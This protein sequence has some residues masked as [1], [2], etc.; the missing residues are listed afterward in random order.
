MAG[1]RPCVAV[2]GGG[3]GGLATAIGLRRRG[4][5]AVVYEQSRA[6]APQGAGIAVGAN[7]HRMLRELGV[8]RRLQDSA[9]APLRA[10]FRHWSTGRR[11]V[12]HA[13]SGAY[14][15]RFK[16]PFWTVERSAVQQALL[17]ELGPEH[18]RLGARC[19]AV[20]DT[21]HGAVIRFAD[22]TEAEADA[23]VGAD[24]IHSAVRDSVF[25]PEAAVFS[26]T[27]GYRALI[28]MERL[29]HLPELAEPVLWLWLGPG[30]HFIAYPVA[31]GRALNF[32]AVVPDRDWLIESWS[33]QGETSELLA[34]FDGWH[35]FVT[36]VLAACERPSRWALYDREPQRTWSRGR[37]TLLG[38]AAHAMLPHH[39]QGANQALEDA[40]VLAHVLGGA[41]PR[42]VT[43]AL[44]AYEQIRRPR[45][46]LLQAGSR[47]NAGCFQLPDG[48]E[49]QARN[50][51]LAALPD[52][53]AWIHGHDALGLLGPASA[54]APV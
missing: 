11:M 2:V 21:G 23:V 48:P 33:T 13:L 3:I 50:E 40:V 42:T 14:E 41:T 52:D 4:V 18:V 7:G 15:E 47:K 6:V 37:V 10:D 32:L 19:A 39:G 20:E 12:V 54:S 51:R 38:D 22:G 34:A 43:E 5:D 49:A 29:A 45:T 26:G 35:P 16:A 8:A 25:G 17:A 1:R 30:R 36:A 28:P 53:L 27:S 46:R 24:G 9:V 31:G 44:R